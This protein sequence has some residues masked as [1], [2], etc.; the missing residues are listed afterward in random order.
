MNCV[1]RLGYYLLLALFAWAPC[2]GVRADPLL[3]DFN[4]PHPVQGYEFRSQGQ[5]P[6]L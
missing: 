5:S 2:D 6:D 1:T 3:A 4:Y